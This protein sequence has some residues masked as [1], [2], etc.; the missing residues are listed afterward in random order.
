M[1][2]ST[3]LCVSNVQEHDTEPPCWKQTAELTILRSHPPPFPNSDPLLS[4]LSGWN[5][6]LSLKLSLISP[7]P[8]THPSLWI[9]NE[10]T[11]AG[12]ARWTSSMWICSGDHAVVDPRRHVQTRNPAIVWVC[13]FRSFGHIPIL[14]SEQKNLDEC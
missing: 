2:D 8:V 3:K 7:T 9:N 12:V 11:E 14:C 10:P 4:F 6:T 5:L 13:L 1:Y